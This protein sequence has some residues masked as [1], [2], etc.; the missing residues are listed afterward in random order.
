MCSFMFDRLFVQSHGQSIQSSSHGV[1]INIFMSLNAN[2][3]HHQMHLAFLR[4]KLVFA[5]NSIQLQSGDRCATVIT[6]SNFR[7]STQ[8]FDNFF[9][10]FC[11]VFEILSLSN[12]PFL[13]SYANRIV[14][15][16]LGIRHLSEKYILCTL[17]TYITSGQEQPHT[18]V[19]VS[20]KYI[21]MC[22]SRMNV[23]R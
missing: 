16:F 9:Y 1:N 23:C 13:I 10:Q 18:Y 8:H 15:T 12:Q 5:D 17:P 11:P 4:H 2:L 22:I 21:C 20:V 14:L 3:I 6:I 7:S 19:Y